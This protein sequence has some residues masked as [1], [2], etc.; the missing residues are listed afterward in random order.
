MPRPAAAIRNSWSMVQVIILTWRNIYFGFMALLATL[1]VVSG[2]AKAVWYEGR[3]G[4]D[5]VST[6]GHVITL[7]CPH[8]GFVDYSFE[9]GGVTYYARD[10]FGNGIP[11]QTAKIG[12]PIAVYYEKGAPENNYGVYPP[13]TPGNPARAAF[14]DN[15]VG[16]GA[17]I[18]LGPFFLAWLWIQAQRLTGR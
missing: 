3:I 15:L 16:F 6:R 8:H 12:Q 10:N 5:P 2:I 17:F 18:F 7:D 4:A 1:F 13:D 9:I 11:C 14:F